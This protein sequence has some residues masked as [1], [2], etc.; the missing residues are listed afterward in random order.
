ML[1]QSAAT[2]QILLMSPDIVLPVSN[3]GLS[4]FI[5]DIS[6]NSKAAEKHYSKHIISLESII[7]NNAYNQWIQPLV[8]CSGSHKDELSAVV[9]SIP[10]GMKIKQ[11]L[12]FDMLP[13]Y[14]AVYSATIY[15]QHEIPSF[16][17]RAEMESI[18]NRVTQTEINW[19]NLR[20]FDTIASLACLDFA[21]LEWED[22]IELRENSNFIYFTNKLSELRK[23]EVKQAGSAHQKILG[24]LFQFLDEMTPQLPASILKGVICNLPLAPV[25][26][27]SVVDS[28]RGI[29]QAKIIKNRFGHLFYIQEI[30]KQQE[31]KI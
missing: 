14:S 7:G 26:P 10:G 13:I 4:E 28:V 2:K 25:N 23:D 29:A 3:K 24:D 30:R 6:K 27:L 19:A 31:N 9:E 16:S 17:L 18:E 8:S 20:L 22:I 12:M 11:K 1:G 21:T 15:A 5:K